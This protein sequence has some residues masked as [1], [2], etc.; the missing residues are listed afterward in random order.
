GDPE[1][2]RLAIR[3]FK[4]ALIQ[5][6]PI[7]GARMGVGGGAAEPYRHWPPFLYYADKSGLLEDI[8]IF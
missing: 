2:M 6:N 3:N 7:F 5:R 8:R 1:W 4:L